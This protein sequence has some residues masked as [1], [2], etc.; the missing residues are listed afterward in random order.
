[1]RL[2]TKS[3]Q[4][5]FLHPTSAAPFLPV[6]TPR[7][8]YL[9]L[10][11]FLHPPLRATA[12]DKEELSRD[13]VVRR[14]ELVSIYN[15]LPRLDDYLTFFSQTVTGSTL[16]KLMH[17]LVLFTCYRLLLP[18]CEVVNFRTLLIQ[19]FNINQPNKLLNLWIS[20]FKEKLYFTSVVKKK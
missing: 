7:W 10:L 17:E 5:V 16:E 4:F 8:S 12:S 9:F 19:A 18:F 20:I 14:G 11:F 2:L 3:E 1:M 15:R 6:K 13:I